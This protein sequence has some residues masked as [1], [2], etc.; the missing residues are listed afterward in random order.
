[1]IRKFGADAYLRL[2]AATRAVISQAGGT[3]WAARGSRVQKSNLSDYQNVNRDDV[4][5]PIDVALDLEALTGD[6]FV[7]RALAREQGHTLIKLP[8]PLDR[9]SW[10]EC[11]GSIS[12]ECGETISA[13]GEAIRGDGEVT[14]EEIRTLNLRAAVDETIETLVEFRHSLGEIERG[15]RS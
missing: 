6:P 9:Q 8:R 4:F 3:E 13:L 2:K 1:M 15:G 10:I 12:K 7:T 11:L 5:M 14:A